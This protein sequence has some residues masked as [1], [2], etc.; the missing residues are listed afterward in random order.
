MTRWQFN[1]STELRPLPS[2]DVFTDA[3]MSVAAYIPMVDKITTTM[4]EHAPFHVKKE[5]LEKVLKKTFTQTEL[6][7]GSLLCFGFNP[8]GRLDFLL[9]FLTDFF[10]VFSIKS[11]FLCSVWQV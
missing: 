9:I 4:T 1:T 3:D 7:Y 6:D 5:M 8:L 11:I 2:S 10:V